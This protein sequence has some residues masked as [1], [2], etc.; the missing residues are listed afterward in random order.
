M[1]SA[2]TSRLHLIGSLL[3]VKIH[4]NLVQADIYRVLT[5]DMDRQPQVELGIRALSSASPCSSR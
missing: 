2:Y 3:N 5:R 1:K 4:R